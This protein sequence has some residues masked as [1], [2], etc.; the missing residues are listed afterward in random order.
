MHINKYWHLTIIKVLSH[1]CVSLLINFNVQL[2]NYLLGREGPRSMW[3][4]YLAHSTN[5]CLLLWAGLSLLILYADWTPKNLQ[6]IPY[7]VNTSAHDK[8]PNFNFGIDYSPAHSRR[9]NAYCSCVRPPSGNHFLI[10]VVAS[11]SMRARVLL[12]QW[13]SKDS[14]G[15]P[16]FGS[17]LRGCSRV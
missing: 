1:H 2:E 16:E 4:A 3:L 8:Q 7:V 17:A 10:I 15:H 14:F 12:G 11:W 6:Q 13:V 5:A 9:T